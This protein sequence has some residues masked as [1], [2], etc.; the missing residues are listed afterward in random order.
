M[1]DWIKCDLPWSAYGEVNGKFSKLDSFESRD[2]NKPGTQVEVNGKLYLI[3]D[4]NGMRGVCD[5]CTEFPDDAI[6]T[7]YRVVWTPDGN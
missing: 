2:L 5:D 4:I 7:R 1:T 3:G 6:V